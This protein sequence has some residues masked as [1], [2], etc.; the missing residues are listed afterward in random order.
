MLSSRP[1]L[2]LYIHSPIQA[3][4]PPEDVRSNDFS[5]YRVTWHWL[6]SRHYLRRCIH[7]PIQALKP[8]YQDV[9]S[10]DFSRYRVTKA[11]A[12]SRPPLRLYIPSPIQALKPPI[13]RVMASATPYP[14]SPLSLLCALLGQCFRHA[15]TTEVVTTNMNPLSCLSPI[16]S[17]RVTWP[18]LSSRGND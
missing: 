4:N 2:R 12:K 3:L 17:V 10:N 18:M 5:R 15:V 8:S 11:N 9:C 7:S 13:V 14:V 16:S 1:H 6:S